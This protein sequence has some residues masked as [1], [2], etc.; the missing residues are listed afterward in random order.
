MQLRQ[1]YDLCLR[2]YIPLLT[3]HVV[4]HSNDQKILLDLADN[5]IRD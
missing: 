2:N 1:Y 5:A 4:F 3:G